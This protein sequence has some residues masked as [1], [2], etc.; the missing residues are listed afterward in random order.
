MG[1]KN[2][3]V[4]VEI[5][6]KIIDG[7][8]RVN[9]SQLI[10]K[11]QTFDDL[12]S[13][14]KKGGLLKIN[15]HFY[16]SKGVKSYPH[17]SLIGFTDTYSMLSKES[18][19]QLT[20]DFPVSGLHC[21]KVGQRKRVW[22]NTSHGSYALNGPAISWVESIGPQLL[23]SDGKPMKL[24]RDHISSGDLSFL[25]TEGLKLCE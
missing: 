5:D 3:K 8:V 15:K 16:D 4:E 22:V 23:G 12:V 11:G 9:G 13:S 7:F 18:E 17:F 19:R 6:G 14:L 25:I 24:G 10:Y 1:E 20:N 2:S 21:K